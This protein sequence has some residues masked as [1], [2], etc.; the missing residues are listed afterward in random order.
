MYCKK[1][2]DLNVSSNV[3]ILYINEVVIFLNIFLDIDFICS[4][5]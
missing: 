3:V 1:C 5:C 4:K 2:N